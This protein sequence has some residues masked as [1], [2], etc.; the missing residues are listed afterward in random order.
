MYTFLYVKIAISMKWMLYK[1]AKHFIFIT[2]SV[3][4]KSE[5]RWEAEQR[6]DESRA[7]CNESAVSRQRQPASHARHTLSQG[8]QQAVAFHVTTPTHAHRRR[9][10]RRRTTAWSVSMTTCCVLTPHVT[11]WPYRATERP[12]W[13]TGRPYWP[14]GPTDRPAL[15]T[16]RPYWPTGR[17]ALL[18]DRPYWP[19]SPTD[20]PTGR[21]YW[22][23][24]PTDRPALLPDRPYWLTGWP[25][26]L[27]DRPYWP[28]GPIDRPALL[29][30]RP[31]W[32]TGPTDRPA[33]LTD[34][35]ALLS[36]LAL[37]PTSMGLPS[38]VVYHTGSG[39]WPSH[40]PPPTPPHTTDKQSPL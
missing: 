5:S 34:R 8:R 18:T 24:G 6:S 11:G 26:L 20:W 9:H 40:T 4:R 39:Q 33:L 21:P 13:P 36:L 2:V 30:D 10:G 28:T 23:T 3:S 37:E 1:P 22:P 29:T 25:A 31:Y 16:D 35:P 7:N 15:L 17:P 12:C 38:A 14:T 27:T 32:L 19:T